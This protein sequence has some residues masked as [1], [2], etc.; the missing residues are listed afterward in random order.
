MKRYTLLFIAFVFSLPLWA[1]TVLQPG[2]IAMVTVNTDGDDLFEFIPLV[3]LQEGTVIHFTDDAW[4][5]S[6]FRDGEG[7]MSYTVPPGGI[8]AGTLIGSVDANFEQTNSGF[9]LSASGDNILVYQGSSTHKISD[10]EYQNPTFILGIGVGSGSTWVEDAADVS[11][12]NSIIP[13][14]LSEENHTIFSMVSDNYQYKE[15]A[16]TKGTKEEL[17]ESLV[18]NTKINKS[19]SKTYSSFGQNFTVVSTP[20]TNDSDSEIRISD[21]P[22]ADQTLIVAE[23]AQTMQSVFEFTI[24]DKGTADG[25]PTELTQVVLKKAAANTLDW[26][27][28]LNAATLHTGTASITAVRSENALRFSIPK[29]SMSIADGTSQTFTLKLKII[30]NLAEGTKFQAQI[31]TAHNFTAETTGSTFATPL[32]ASIVSGVT[33]FNVQATKLRF[34]TQPSNTQVNTSISPPIEIE[35]IDE[36]GNRDTD[37]TASISLMAFDIAG[38]TSLNATNGIASFAAVHFSKV[39]SGIRITAKSGNFTVESNAFEVTDMVNATS[40]IKATT[41]STATSITPNKTVEVF[42]FTIEDKG[43]DTYPTRVTQIVVSPAEGNELSWSKVLETAKLEV[44]DAAISVAADITDTA[45]TFNFEENVLTVAEGT[46]LSCT[47]SVQLATSTI[48][49]DKVLAFQIAATGHQAST[50]TTQSSTFVKDFG[51]A[52]ISDNITTEIE[53]TKLLITT[54]PTEEVAG[55]LFSLPIVA[56]L[57]DAYGNIDANSTLTATIR[58]ANGTGTLSPTSSLS[59]SPQKG[60]YTWKDLSYDRAE[61]AAFEIAAQDL[62]IVSDSVVFVAAQSSLIEPSIAVVA[63]DTI[64]SSRNTAGQ[65]K[66]FFKFVLKDQGDDGL[67]TIVEKIR[68]VKG[69][70]FSQ[71]RLYYLIGGIILKQDNISIGQVEKLSSSNGYGDVEIP[72]TKPLVIADGAAVEITTSIFASTHSKLKEGEKL[73][74]AIAEE[75]EWETA[76]KGTAIITPLPKELVSPIFTIDVV[77]THLTFEEIPE[78]IAPGTPFSVSV[79]VVDAQGT[80]DENYSGTVSLSREAGTGTL[81][82]ETGL[83]LQF[84]NGK[85]TWTDAKYDVGES[86]TLLA[87]SPDFAPIE[88]APINAN[89]TDS[90]LLPAQTPVPDATI[91]S[92][93][94]NEA[95]AQA[96]FA[97][98]LEDKGT[99]DGKPTTL[100]QLVF[101]NTH[102]ANEANW[103]TNIAGAVLLQDGKAV[104]VTDKISEEEITFSSSA[105]IATIADASKSAFVL[106]IYLKYNNIE[107]NKTFRCKIAATE[108]DWKV[109]ATGSALQPL[110]T[111]IVSNFATIAV[112]ATQLDFLQAPYA[113]NTATETFSVTVAARDSNGNIDSDY[114][115]TINLK[116]KAAI[117][118]A[119]SNSGIASFS[120]LSSNETADFVLTA[121]SNDLQ[122]GRHGITISSVSI[123]LEENFESG[124]LQDW[125]PATNWKASILNP[126]SGTN[127]LK[128]NLTNTS[129][130]STIAKSIGNFSLKNATT[131]WRWQMKNGDWN[132]SSSTKFCYV[133]AATTLSLTEG[134]YYAVGTNQEGSDDL[135]TL[136]KIES[137][138]ASKLLSSEMTWKESQVAGI[139]VKLDSD[140]KWELS[141]DNNG[142]FDNLYLTGTAI[143]APTLS[144]ELFSGLVFHY[145]TASRAGLFWADDVHIYHFNTAPQVTAL[146]VLSATQ[147][148][149]SFNQKMEQKSIE[150]A[151]N[152]SFT[153]DVLVQKAVFKAPDKVRLTLS[154]LQTDSYKITLKNIESVTNLSLADTT[155]SFVYFR[156]AQQGDVLINELMIDE[157]PPTQLPEYEYIEIYNNTEQPCILKDWTLTVGKYEKKLSADTLQP[158]EYL[159]L[160]ATSAQKALATYGKTLVVNAFP[161]L[162]NTSGTV[163]LKNASGLEI[164]KIS[165]EKLWYNDAE[166]ENG[167]WSLE[168]INPESP[169]NSR[170]NWA[171]SQDQRGGTPGAKNSVFGIVLDNIPPSLSNVV[172][173][174]LNQL[175]VT[176]SEP[177]D[178]LAIKH[179]ELFFVNGVGYPENV[180]VSEDAT[181]VVLVF[182]DDFEYGNTYELK[183]KEAVDLF[184]NALENA[185]S[186]FGLPELALSNELIINEILFNPVSGNVDYV[187]LYNR[188]SKILDLA[189]L[190][191][192][193]RDAKNALKL[194][195]AMST[196]SRLLNP[197]EFVVLTTNIDLVKQ[198]YK[199]KNPTAMLEIKTLPSFPNDAGVVV[200]LNQ[201][202]AIIDEFHYSEAMHL[203]LLVSTDGVALERMQ[204]DLPTQDSNNWHSAA[205]TVGFGTPSYQNSAYSE[206][207]SFDT[208]IFIA[209]KVFSPNGDGIDDVMQI[210]YQFDAPGKVA[211]V[212]IFDSKGRLVLDV[213]HSLTLDTKGIIS[214]DGVNADGER[215]RSGRYIVFIELFDAKGNVSI[216][217]ESCVLYGHFN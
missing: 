10:A 28:E 24:T 15:A 137:G 166:K 12:K 140:G 124:T 40:I 88:S 61:T 100:T 37:Y 51:T 36:N 114:F 127:S 209:P 115:E 161:T 191:I 208:A 4:K 128:H 141:Y 75:H 148:E 143:D 149:I 110:D 85:A 95:S 34:Q 207:A 48:E 178:N 172:P 135:L 38:T 6:E 44:V 58:V 147:L 194:V 202:A 21:T 106:S 76:T 73:Q 59:L 101:K 118:S 63:S 50:A 180:T 2:D 29:G 181:Q 60:S 47:V 132:P 93:I 119:N 205:E 30:S 177:I 3:N 159:L 214:W 156:E 7:V 120:N 31:E 8:V 9:T 204:Y 136:W 98:A 107:D 54:Q 167:G 69:E 190:F 113:L 116:D 129:G 184:G 200:L 210:H 163:V 153:N 173:T 20:S 212:S 216:Y 94:A 80:V 39:A 74:L 27:N 123:D 211:N 174:A 164:D 146:K 78:A 170:A 67:P 157:T 188:S 117:A 112:T 139:Q 142:G 121:E 90:E 195:Y 57:T 65:A 5:G 79:A 55:T 99:N 196:T 169:S 14:N 42:T 97:F 72:L 179:T 171:A 213:A 62:T 41:A 26:V 25:K 32:A 89:D 77:A 16:I 125:S 126:I 187:E 175:T 13:S 154:E 198:Q 182:K 43:G 96:V 64:L 66:D 192:A 84:I 197:K 160:C 203:K 133:L 189:T 83:S 199:V 23:A 176:F 86:F 158:K 108:T 162:T 201:E 103:K 33:T 144:G 111:D 52:I 56:Q 206:Y 102:P 11:T 1:Q 35:A 168:R 122:T 193:S 17:L 22:I 70:S 215:A 45:L 185:S 186:T 46:T 68:F 183:V 165:Y 92:T 71:S 49:E 105:G 151:E 19:S 145:E 152:Y 87:T 91:A 138:K 155:L 53:A 150:T 18:D 130:I 109:N 217:K 82:S 134:T 81:L 104:A 131:V